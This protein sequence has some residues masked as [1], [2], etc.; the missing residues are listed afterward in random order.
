MLLFAVSALL[1]G[2]PIAS[3]ASGQATFLPPNDLSIPVDSP[4]AKGIVEAQFN[5][6]LNTIEKIY[7]PIVA[8]RGGVL[9]INRKW[10]D[11][12]V[13]A[14]AQQSGKTYILNMYGGLARHETVTMDGFALV[15][16]HELGHHLGGA[17]KIGG[18]N[19]WASNE[20]QSDYYANLKCLRMVFADGDTKD[21]THMSAGDEVAENACQ[22][23]FPKAEDQA[24]C[25]RG[26]MAG[27]SVAY[28]FKALRNETVTPRF[29]T[30]DTKVQTTML[31]THPPTQC[32]M[33]T[34]LQGSL[35]AQ[36]VGAALSE[37]DPTVGTCT[38]SAGFPGGYRP[39]CWY[40]PA[41]AAEL[42]PPAARPFEVAEELAPSFGTLLN[43][44][45]W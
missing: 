26:A 44:H 1:L 32:R 3:S 8:A 12:T 10:T 27:K 24:I 15:A 22:A 4:M 33:D 20:G 41:N 37:K 18:W 14:S 39:L 30:P 23:A 38:R 17:P 34:Y 11:A 19:P 25:F 9:Q 21:F 6:V 36:P 13:N 29:D 42:L 31:A 43:G 7:K 40:K 45:S 16:C 5:K 2:S 35:C 28:L